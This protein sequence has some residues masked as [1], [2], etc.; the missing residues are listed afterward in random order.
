MV[1]KVTASTLVEVYGE[2]RTVTMQIIAHKKQ[3]PNIA[4]AER[5]AS[6]V[7]G[8]IFAI[9]GLQKRTRGGVAVAL[10]GTDLVRRGITGHSNLY[11]FLGTRTAPVGQGAHVSVPYE[12]GIRVDQAI[13]INRPRR[14]IYRFW[15][16]LSNLPRFMKH[17]ESVREVD[18]NRSHW[19]VKAPAGRRVQ[20]DAVIHNEI[21]NELI[22]WRSIRGGDVDHAG[23]VWFRDEPG[24]RGTSVKV[25][26]QYNPPAGILGAVVAAL[27]GEEP[28]AQIRDD[29]RR[30]KKELESDG[31]A[32]SLIHREEMVDFALEATFPAS[33]APAY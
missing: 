31:R 5:A 25:E 18:R 24:G 6:I 23:S 13:S 19:V 3:P 27:W 33:D 16:Q 20:W 15:R 8:G 2:G 22:A 29:L 9:A 4:Y 17:L 21:E 32:A 1:A 10:I 7:G 30:L 26:L 14:E 12:L 11:E 28:T